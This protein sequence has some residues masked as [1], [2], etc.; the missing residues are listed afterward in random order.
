MVIKTPVPNAGLIKDCNILLAAKST[1]EGNNWKSGLVNQQK[2]D[3]K[4]GNTAV[5]GNLAWHRQ[6]GISARTELRCWA[7][8]GAT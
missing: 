8:I 7:C 3:R 6:E 1:L 2:N 4:T 5:M